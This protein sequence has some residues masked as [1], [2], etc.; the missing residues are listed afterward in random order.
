M[1]NFSLTVFSSSQNS[2]HAS[3]WG[4]GG[5]LLPNMGYI[6]LFGPKGCNSSAALVINR[7]SVLVVNLDILAIESSIGYMFL[8]RSYFFIII[9]KSINK[10]HKIC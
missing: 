1:T 9:N 6:G 7:V 10:V 5:R 8:G 3:G 2:F 4:G